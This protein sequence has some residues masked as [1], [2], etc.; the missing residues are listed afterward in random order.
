MKKA[1]FAAGLV[2]VVSAWIA[3]A[4][5]AATKDKSVEQPQGTQEL[6]GGRP[7]R[8]GIII[9]Q[10]LLRKLKEGNECEIELAMLVQ[11][12]SSSQEIKTLAKHLISD[13]REMNEKLEEMQH[14]VMHT[15]S[16]ANAADPNPSALNFVV[17]LGFCK[18]SER[19]CQNN[20]E[21]TKQTL[22]SLQGGDF[23]LAYLRQLSVAHAMTLAEL[24]AITSD[25][26]QELKATANE[27]STQVQENLNAIKVLVIKLEGDRK[28]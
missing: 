2:V 9:E 21:M 28:L 5:E 12:L 16:P 13:Y 8:G 23:D 18:I 14:W 7:S 3:Y 24:A 19:A 20:L 10:A 17:P 22:S 6:A 25:G 4:Q 15:H 26:P 11:E 1:F 27:A